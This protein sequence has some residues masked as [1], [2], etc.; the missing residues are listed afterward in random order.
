MD[1]C[2]LFWEIGRFILK[3]RGSATAADGASMQARAFDVMMKKHIIKGME[4]AKADGL[5]QV[6]C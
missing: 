2:G 3:K 6:T 5:H 4:K 1:H